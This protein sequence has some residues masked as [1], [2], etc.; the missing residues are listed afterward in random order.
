MG[1]DTQP[2]G[3]ESRGYTLRLRGTPM[4]DLQPTHE[5][6]LTAGD[7]QRI[8]WEYFGDGTREAVCLFNGRAMH[9]KAWSRSCRSWS[10][11]STFCCTTIPARATRR[12][13]LARSPSPAW[14]RT[15]P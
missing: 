9:P 13:R 6:V 15:L 2:P 10:G 14:P 7:G 1:I 11:S 5:R 3:R 12:M 8:H 4:P